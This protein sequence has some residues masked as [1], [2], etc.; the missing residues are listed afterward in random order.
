M[1][2]QQS[3]EPS[4]PSGT[5]EAKKMNRCGW[6]GGLVKAT[7]QGLCCPWCG[8]AVEREQKGLGE[9]VEA[10]GDEDEC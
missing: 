2:A 6:C 7:K 1:E 4:L 9:W 5:S 3:N 8:K 10:G